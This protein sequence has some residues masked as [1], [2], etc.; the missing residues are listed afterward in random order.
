M[1]LV[2]DCQPACC[3]TY[4]EELQV[5]PQRSYFLLLSSC[6]ALFF[7]HFQ[8]SFFANRNKMSQ[9]VFNCPSNRRSFTSSSA[10]DGGR[11]FRIS[12]P[13]TCPSMGSTCGMRGNTTSQSFHNFGGRQRMS[14]CAGQN[15]QGSECG[16]R[17]N[18]I[19]EVCVNKH[20]LQPLFLG[21]DPN[22]HRIKAN[23]KEQIKALNNQFACFIDKVR[24]YQLFSLSL[25]V[26]WISIKKEIRKWLNRW[27]IQIRIRA[28]TRKR[29]AIPFHPPLCPLLYLFLPVYHSVLFVT[30]FLSFFLSLFSVPV[31]FFC[32]HSSFYLFF[33]FPMSLVFLSFSPA[34]HHSLSPLSLCCFPACSCPLAYQQWCSQAPTCPPPQQH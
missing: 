33:C 24:L 1:L 3:T 7:Q 26:I 5:W 15:F 31:T 12:Q 13:P 6:V 16:C 10:I 19:R 29:A 18:G 14:Y 32:P 30:L 28:P 20:L 22:D 17:F 9:Q 4:K 27:I 21:V 34:P 23:E 8:A 11:G 2:S 25:F